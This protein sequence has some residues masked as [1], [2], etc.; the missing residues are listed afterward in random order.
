MS[1]LGTRIEAVWH[2]AIVV[3]GVEHYF[4]GG[5]GIATA[6]PGTTRFGR[7]MRVDH[8]GDT[9][10]TMDE[11]IAWNSQM[12]ATKYGPFDYNLL[13]RNCNHYT[14]DAAQFLVGRGI[15]DDVI[16]QVDRLLST[17]LGA[18]FRPMLE[19]ISMAPDAAAGSGVNSTH[20]DVPRSAAPAGGVGITLEQDTA[21]RGLLQAMEEEVSGTSSFE[22]AS[23]CLDTIATVLDNVTQHPSERRYQTLNTSS[24]VWTNIISLGE[25]TASRI[26]ELAGFRRVDAQYMLPEGP[27]AFSFQLLRD[28]VPIIRGSR[29]SIEQIGQAIQASLAD[30]SS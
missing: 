17:P 15:A 9:T 1:L 29:D 8:L 11:F 7:A 14:D 19:K 2:T 13:Q 5:L 25:P 23:R 24:P 12:M 27:G 4:D 30:Q 22:S 28:M 20:S 16:N 10:R 26:L 21:L 3:G 18:M 6:T